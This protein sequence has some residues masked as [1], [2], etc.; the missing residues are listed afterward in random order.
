MATTFINYVSDSPD[1]NQVESIYRE[2][3]ESIIYEFCTELSKE[4]AHRD[5]AKVIEVLQ[6]YL[7]KGI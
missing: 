4:D 5:L 1:V 6:S 2:A 7:D 3:V